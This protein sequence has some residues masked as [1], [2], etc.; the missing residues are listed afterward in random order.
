MGW[1]TRKRDG[2]EKAKSL[3]QAGGFLRE[4][5]RALIPEA[6]PKA[7]AQASTLISIIQSSPMVD[8]E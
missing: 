6:E 8:L 7:K 3:G 5:H 1:H 2:D 4:L